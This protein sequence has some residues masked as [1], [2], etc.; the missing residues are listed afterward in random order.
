MTTVS[1]FFDA[2]HTNRSYRSALE[3][4]QIAAMMLDLSGIDF[5][6]ALIKN[7]FK[8]MNRLTPGGAKDFS[9]SPFPLSDARG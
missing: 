2:L 1:D 7:F 8:T 9:P 6:P 5:N 3:T 4:D